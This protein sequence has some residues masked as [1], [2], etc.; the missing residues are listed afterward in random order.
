[1]KAL[2]VAA[3]S[4]E[5]MERSITRIAIIGAGAV[6]GAYGAMLYD[7]DPASVSFVAR[8]DRLRRL[9]HRGL[10]VNGKPYH[11]HVMDADDAGPPADLLIVA[12]KHHHLEEALAEMRR[13]IGEETIILSLMNGVESEEQIGRVHGADHIL[14]AIVI[15]IDAVREGN[16]IT[17]PAGA[18]YAS[19]RQAA[20]RRARGSGASRRSS[21]EPA[22]LVR[23]PRT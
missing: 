2:P 6:G 23:R 5:G 3:L 12:V 11:I 22:S 10:V 4:E 14:P 9:K 8:G 1:V 19:A 15:G 7:A 17:I 21:S 20:G 16:S 18:G 13:R